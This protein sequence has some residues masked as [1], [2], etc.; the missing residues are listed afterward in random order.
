MASA[1]SPAAAGHEGGENKK[2]KKAAKSLA[3]I[4]EERMRKIQ[5]KRL[6]VPPK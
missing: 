2:K 5:E 4:A 6:E 1:S 3:E